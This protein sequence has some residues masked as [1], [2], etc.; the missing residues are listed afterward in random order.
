MS[1]YR[2]GLGPVSILSSFTMND[3]GGW[4]FGRWGICSPYSLSGEGCKISSPFLGGEEHRF[5]FKIYLNEFLS[6]T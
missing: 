2:L 1:L 3:N 6:Y 4:G 5:H